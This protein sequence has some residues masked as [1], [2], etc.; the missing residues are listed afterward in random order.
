MRP[1]LV[2]LDGG[3]LQDPVPCYPVSRAVAYLRQRL[4]VPIPDESLT[5]ATAAR[6]ALPADPTEARLLASIGTEPTHI[7]E[8]QQQAGLPI[9]QV[10]AA[11]ALMELKGMVRQ[12]GGM[13]Y[14]GVREQPADYQG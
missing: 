10:T 11:L 3:G 13:H 9:E 8:I 2:K 12:V 14:I 6:Q 5:I 4:V 7:D 1:V